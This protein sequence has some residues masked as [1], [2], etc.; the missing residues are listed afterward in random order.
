MQQQQR[1]IVVEAHLVRE[2]PAHRKPSAAQKKY[3]P[4]PFVPAACES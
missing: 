3:E 1:N 4:V 2:R